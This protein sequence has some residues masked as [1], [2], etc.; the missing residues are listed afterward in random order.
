MPKIISTIVVVGLV[1][2]AGIFGYDLIMR[3]QQVITIV[4]A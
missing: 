3:C 4:T 1:V 2:V